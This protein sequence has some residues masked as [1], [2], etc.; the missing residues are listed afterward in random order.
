MKKVYNDPTLV[1][2]RKGKFEKP[3]NF[4]LDCGTMYTDSSNTYVP[5]SLS[6]DEGVLF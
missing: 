6:D 5:P 2:Y 3:A 1:Q 4:R